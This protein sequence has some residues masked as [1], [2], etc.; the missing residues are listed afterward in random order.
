[1]KS[2]DAFA[3]LGNLGKPVITTTEA[4]A[5][6]RMDPPST[7]KTLSRLAASNLVR[8]IRRGIW[9]LGSD[10]PD[11]FEVA[12]VLTR[13][14][15]NYVSMYSA[16]FRHGMIDQIPRTIDL[17]SLGRPMKLETSV[18]F[19]TIH[20]LHEE[21]FDGFIGQSAIRSGL[22]TAEKA[23]VDTVMVLGVRGG[24][25]TLPEIDLPIDFDLQSMWA[26]VERISS[27]R[28]RTITI[29]NLKRMIEPANANST[30][31]HSL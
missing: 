1:M 26:W 27:Q 4:A 14:Y 30:P 2:I 21:S 10:A 9:S 25:V 13:P 29:R 3:K 16:L 8:N 6:W 19:F 18:G 31:V 22:A 15:P 17:M 20:H 7:S 28:L 12:P 5:V 23:L 11:S 24:V